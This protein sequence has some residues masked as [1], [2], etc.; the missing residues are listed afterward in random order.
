MA[1]KYF[2]RTGVLCDSQG[3]GK[4]TGYA[5]GN[6][7]KNPE[8]KNNPEMQNIPDV[9]PLPRGTYTMLAPVPHPK[10]GPLA[11]PLKPDP[12]NEMFGRGGFYCH[13]DSIENPGNVS[14]GCIV[15]PLW[16]RAMLATSQDRVIVVQ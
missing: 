11:I 4:A 16:I 12:S 3:C 9:G 10:L 1:W 5:G 13:G 8:G 14:E 7:G 15:M 6:C 2:Q